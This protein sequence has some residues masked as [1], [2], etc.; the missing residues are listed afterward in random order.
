[1]RYV[2]PF[3][4]IKQFLK[5]AT[6]RGET[7]VS[8]KYEEAQGMIRALLSAFDVDEAWYMEQN[9]DVAS[10][11]RD[12]SIRSA[13]EH[14]VDHGYFEGRPPFSVKIDEK[15]YLEQNP[16]VAETV[17]RGEY[18]SAQDHYDGPGYR[19]GRMPFPLRPPSP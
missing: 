1:M 19:E 5:F 11:V 6:I 17:K 18:K 10:G 2:P 14:F 7:V 3:E 8:M 9:P 12:G 15:W 4:S 13:R 16:D